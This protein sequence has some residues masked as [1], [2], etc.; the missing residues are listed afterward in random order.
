MTILGVTIDTSNVPDADFRDEAEASIG[1]AA[2]FARPPD[3]ELVKAQGTEVADMAIDADEVE[4][5]TP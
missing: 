5:E 2:F 4:Y 1:A 3:G